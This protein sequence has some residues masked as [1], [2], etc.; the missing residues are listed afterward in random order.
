MKNVLIVALL[1]LF[2][3]GCKETAPKEEKSTLI[4]KDFP[5]VWKGA[6]LYFLLT[7][8]FNNGNP[9]NDINFDRTKKTG[10][11]RGFEGGD[12]KG[13][14]EKIDSGYFEELGINAIWL[15]PIVE[16]IHASVDEGTGN[17]YGYHGY[18]TKDWTSLDPNFGTKEDLK[19]LVEKAHAKGIRIV[20]DAV[21]NHTGPATELDPVWPDEW[22]RTEPLC[23]FESYE[24]T[25]A[26]TLVEN[27]PD[28]KTESNESVEL[29][30]FLIKKWQ[31]EGRYDIEMQELNSF[32]ERTG[33]AKT[34]RFYIIKWLTDFITEF[35]IDGFRADTVKHTEESVWKEFKNECE[36]AFAQWKLNNPTKVLDSNNF[37]LVGEVYNW[38]ISQAKAFD[39]GDKKV[40]YYDNGFDAMINFEIKSDAKNDYESIFSKYNEILNNHFDSGNTVLNYLTSHDDGSPFDKERVKPYESGTK[41]LLTPGISQVY[42]GDESARPLIIEG[43]VGDATLRSNMNWNEIKSDTT[44]QKILK[45]WQKLGQFRR[46]H[47]A[48]GAGTHHMISE[49]PY[50]FSRNLKTDKFNDH[51]IIGLDLPLGVKEL[52][53]DSIFKDGTILTDRYSGKEVTVEKGIVSLNSEETIVLL[54]NK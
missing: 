19:E 29:P 11:L 10:E 23:D 27:L 3:F 5:F 53:M 8:R 47:P 40:N 39:F 22:V 41:L 12:I 44:T 14:T 9:D 54:E 1:L 33:Y 25:T 48:I 6:N 26:C 52:K 45:H 32:F 20:L 24:T 42:Y 13:I 37:F 51:V 7:D 15:T 43:T 17:S 4:E 34:P 21:I 2:S 31:D 28:I 36:F 16:Q 35:G 46:D 30:D 50:V 18:W 38:N 49:T